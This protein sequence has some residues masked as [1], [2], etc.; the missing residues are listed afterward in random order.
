MPKSDLS[1]TTR[2][3]KIVTLIIMRLVTL[4]LAAKRKVLF[5]EPAP[6]AGL[7]LQKVMLSYSFGWDRIHNSYSYDSSHA[8]L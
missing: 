6:E 4:K 3:E 7:L 2:C 1:S 8:L 5:N